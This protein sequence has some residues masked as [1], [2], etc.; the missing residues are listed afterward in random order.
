MESGPGVVF[1]TNNKI[2]NHS[3]E[4]LVPC[5]CVMQRKNLGDLRLGVSA[6]DNTM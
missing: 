4:G 1:Y 5:L 2:M 6:A 3:F